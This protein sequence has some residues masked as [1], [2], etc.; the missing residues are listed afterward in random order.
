M[1]KKCKKCGQKN[2]LNATFCANCGSEL[3][4]IN[5]KRLSIILVVVVVIIAGIGYIKLQ[6]FDSK[7]RDIEILNTKEA[8]K[9]IFKDDKII[10]ESLDSSLSSDLDK[11]INDN[12]LCVNDLYLEEPPK[13]EIIE[14]DNKRIRDLGEGYYLVEELIKNGNKG[15]LEY[16]LA[17]QDIKKID[18]SINSDKYDVTL[19]DNDRITKVYQD[20]QLLYEI[21]YHGDEIIY[22]HEDGSYIQIN[23]NTKDYEKK[24]KDGDSTTQ[25]DYVIEDSYGK[26]D[27]KYKND[28][29][30]SKFET[31][32][33][34]NN[35]YYYYDNNGL[36]NVCKTKNENG[37]L[38]FGN[39]YF[40]DFENGYI[41]RMLIDGDTLFTIEQY[42]IDF[43][44]KPYILTEFS[45]TDDFL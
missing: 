28:L 13:I 14:E 15:T 4:T 23:T 34:D 45:V 38:S 43:S 5:I 11:I 22:Y 3:K 25:E 41:Y 8:R 32:H 26:Y 19:D 18:C 29:L 20:H 37:E 35:E 36:I 44:F 40:Y 10:Q 7:V 12:Y 42:T 21:E 30:I 33:S 27:V 9:E 39:Y 24:Y 2:K 17:D 1:M 16:Y 31:N 6:L